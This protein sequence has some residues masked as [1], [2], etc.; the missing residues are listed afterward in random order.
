M[1][2]Y[3]AAFF[4]PGKIVGKPRP[5]A[6]AVPLFKHGK[7]VLDKKGHPKYRGDT[8]PSKVADV[9]RAAVAVEARK[10]RP[11]VP[12]DC[13]MFIECIFIYRRP[14][15]HFVNRNRKRGTLKEN[16]PEWADVVPDGDNAEGVVWDALQDAGVI[17][18]DKGFCKW[19]G[20]KSYTSDDI[21]NVPGVWIE[22][23]E[24]PR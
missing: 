10:Y 1:P 13:P 14:D 23:E 21:G 6:K 4:V 17:K 24:L 19:A 22:I 8:Y 18:N 16:A 2:L 5:R 12:L 3:S 15:E 20:L 9:F 11:D 7:P